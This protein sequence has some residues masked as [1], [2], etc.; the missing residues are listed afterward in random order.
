MSF[1]DRF[2]E[3]VSGWVSSAPFFSFCIL[4]VFIWAPSILILK[5]LDTWQLIINTTT[6]IITFLMVALLE[7]GQKQFEHA[8]HIKLDAVCEALSVVLELHGDDEGCYQIRKA[9]G[10]E[11]KVGT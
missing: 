9:I 7:N 1:F 10:A 4:L 8:V 3:R 6:T 5:D 2:A 11:N